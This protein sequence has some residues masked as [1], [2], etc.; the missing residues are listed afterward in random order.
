MSSPVSYP[1]RRLQQKRKTFS[2]SYLDSFWQ[3]CDAIN[4]LDPAQSWSWQYR[5][6]IRVWHMSS[7]WLRLSLSWVF[8]DSLTYIAVV[9]SSQPYP[10][11]YR[12]EADRTSFKEAVWRQWS[13]IVCYYHAKW[14]SR[15]KT[16]LSALYQGDSIAEVRSAFC[17]P[18][19]WPG[20]WTTDRIVLS[21][22]SGEG[23]GL[24]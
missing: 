8:Q 9:R 19:V 5:I 14:G 3:A 16:L 6:Y 22:A 4:Q 7:L 15:V 12:N 23:L 20:E 10:V 2:K 1:T 13:G 17:Y 24:L 11:P 18:R 21:S